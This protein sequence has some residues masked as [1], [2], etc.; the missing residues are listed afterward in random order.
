MDRAE[1]AHPI[2]IVLDG[3]NYVI[4][5]QAMS[6]FIKGKRLWRIIN[7]TL[8][9]PVQNA[10]ETENAFVDRLDEWDGK[11]YQIIT[12]FRNTCLPSISLQF[13]RFQDDDTIASPAKAIWDFLKERYQTTGHAHQYQ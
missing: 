9:K 13:G 12:W 10:N 4:W 2:P 7:G 1:I 11:T 8:N 3:S 6:G 5:A